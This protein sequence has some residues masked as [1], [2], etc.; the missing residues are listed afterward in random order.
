M[1][2]EHSNV[3]TSG[4]VTRRRLLRGGAVIGAGL[5]AA[6]MG[7]ASAP[8]KPPAAPP[9]P[10]ASSAAGAA[11]PERPGVPVVKGAPKNGGTWTEAV[12]LTSPQ[13]DMHTAL[14]ASIWHSLSERA[15]L[16]DPWTNEMRANIIEKWEIPDNTHF[17][18]QVRKGI[19]LHN[20][21]PW[22]GRDFDA[23]DL[24]F[25]INRIA[26]NTAAAEGLTKTAF[27]R[28]DTFAGMERVETVEKYSV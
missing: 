5:G 22:S 19:K 28:A 11:A 3:W 20:K 2:A 12:L 13:Q 14:A 4:R 17:V 24:A 8:P 18:L 10:Q 23:E 21:P 25:N 9:A 1:D 6:L 27:Q 26:G 7:C 16:P 15:L